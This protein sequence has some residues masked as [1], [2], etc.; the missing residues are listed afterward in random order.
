MSGERRIFVVGLIGL[1]ALGSLAVTPTIQA[2]D[3]PDQIAANQRLIEHRREVQARRHARAE[4]QRRLIEQMMLR[5]QM[6]MMRRQQVQ[7]MMQSFLGA[8]QQTGI[9]KHCSGCGSLVSPD[10]DVGQNCPFCGTGWGRLVPG[11]IGP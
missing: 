8:S 5:E 2:A 1:V 7:F 11:R 9:W 4:R 6:L 3:R 10:A